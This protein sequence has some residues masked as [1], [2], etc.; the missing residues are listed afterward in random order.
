MK[1]RNRPKFAVSDNGSPSVG[2]ANRVNRS[3]TVENKSALEVT[4]EENTS[5]L[6][7]LTLEDTWFYS[8]KRNAYATLSLLT[9]SW[10]SAG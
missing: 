1:T 4:L 8:P 3:D 9:I 6:S 5:F 10:I 2:A 7:P